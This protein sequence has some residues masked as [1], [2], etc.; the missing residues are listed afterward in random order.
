MSG[1]NA[2]RGASVARIFAATALI[3][4]VALVAAE[5][6][7]GGR[8]SASQHQFAGWP[9]TWHS[10]GSDPAEA[11]C[12]NHRN[13]T[14]AFYA[15]DE[16]TLFLRL[17]NAS[18]AGWPNANPSGEARYKWF[19][20]AGDDA[21]LLGTTVLNADWL[22]VVEDRAT[23]PDPTLGRNLLGEQTLMDDLANVGFTTRWGGG[24]PAGY[25]NNGPASG[26]WR[27]VIGAG[28][29]G[30]GGP[31]EAV[32]DADIGYR[33]TGTNLDMYVRR[34]ALSNPG[35]IRLL[36]ATTSQGSNL[37]NAPAC[38]TTDDFIPL[39]DATPTSANTA[40]STATRTAT[41]TATPTSTALPTATAGPTASNTATP[42]GSE[43]ATAPPTS[44]STRTA[45]ST[46]TRTA[47][48]TS[49]H[50]STPTPTDTSTP[51]A[52][53]SAVPT[54]TGTSTPTATPPATTTGPAT[55]SPT[56]TAPPSAT[57]TRTPT[58]TASSTASPT[59]VSSATVTPPTAS[60]ATSTPSPTPTTTPVHTPTLTPLPTASA[61]TTL[62]PTPS[63][64]PTPTRS[65]TAT[66]TPTAS[67]TATSTATPTATTT[68]TRV[69]TPRADA[70]H[71]LDGDGIV[72]YHDL[73]TV[74]QRWG[75]SSSSPDPDN[76]PTTPN[77][78]PLYDVVANGDIDAEDI[79]A[80][81][82]QLGL[83]CP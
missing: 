75:L 59:A 17:Q 83:G 18:D 16:D 66:R 24:S 35:T 11:G 81:G 65:P 7:L 10:I 12:A 27:R 80:V 60:P 72:T 37:D 44:T 55:S 71:D 3:G 5:S 34:S 33:I 13:G 61:T 38:D 15:L 46:P 48:S 36:W 77:Y 56:P 26:L 19:I 8:H 9:G 41:S 47:S 14:G 78:E 73:D 6:G 63:R 67:R 21:A 64:T 69:V 68:P 82:K 43:S 30:A 49:T 45:T 51:T 70:C 39:P 20:D 54:A 42:S 40:T 52:S 53:A 76:D 57:P 2:V 23:A 79:A 74:L 22:L 58:G 29:P 32:G 25:M 50:T 4:A 1:G 28:T 62:S 31:Q